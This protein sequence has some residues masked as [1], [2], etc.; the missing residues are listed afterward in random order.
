MT[1]L[2]NDLFDESNEQHTSSKTKV[3]MSPAEVYKTKIRENIQKFKNQYMIRKNDMTK[4]MNEEHKKWLTNNTKMAQL[5]IGLSQS[6]QNLKTYLDSIDAEEYL[7]KGEKRKT[8]FV[9]I[10]ILIAITGC[11]YLGMSLLKDR[12]TSTNMY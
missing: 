2:E 6:Q 7:A 12:T 11:G 4:Y 10:A 1:L 9:I 3:S 5:D 8:I